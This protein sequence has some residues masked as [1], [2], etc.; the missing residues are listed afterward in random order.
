M[1]KGYFLGLLVMLPALA[2]TGCSNGSDPGNKLIISGV[3]GIST[4]GIVVM[5][6]ADLPLSNNFAAGGYGVVSGTSA[7]VVYL[8]NTSPQGYGGAGNWTGAGEYYLFVWESVTGGMFSGLPKYQTTT[9]VNFQTE[10][11]S[12]DWSLFSAYP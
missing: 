8:E 3:T 7:T 2:F 11:T 4:P 5:L 9:K 1:K 10:T 12:V 6:K